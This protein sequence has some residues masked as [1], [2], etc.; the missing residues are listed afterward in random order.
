MSALLKD[1]LDNVEQVLLAQSKIP[2]N[3]GH[4]LDA[5]SIVV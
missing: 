1:H 5:I 4:S 3:S 2:A